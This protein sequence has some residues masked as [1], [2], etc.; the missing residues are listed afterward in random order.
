MNVRALGKEQDIT[1]NFLDAMKLI[2]VL[3]ANSIHLAPFFDCALTNL[4]AVDS[5]R[6]ITKDVLSSE[7]LDG[8]IEPDEQLMLLIDAIHILNK[9]AG[10]D[11]EP[12]TSQFSRIVL[13]NPQHF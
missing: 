2:P 3:R 5:L 1:G 12:H 9:T 8:G 11:L 13:E 4:Y 10:F 6:I 7:L